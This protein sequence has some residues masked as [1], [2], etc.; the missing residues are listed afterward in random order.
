MAMESLLA[1]G[2][3]PLLLSLLGVAV[4]CGLFGYGFRLWHR[5]RLIEDVP[6]AKIRSMPLGRVEIAGRAREKELLEAPISGVPCV[7]FRYQVEEEVGSGRHRRWRTVARGDSSETPFYV[8]DETGR[9]RVDPAGATLELRADLSR[10]R[11]RPGDP[12]FGRLE[13]HGWARRRWLGL[14]RR[15]RVSEW[16]IAPDRPVYVLGVAQ[17]RG[18]LAAER[19]RAIAASLAEVKHD[20][21]ALARLDR[22]GD[23]RVDA[24]EWEVARRA[25]VAAVDLEAPED[26][27]VI[28]RAPA[29]ESAFVLSD[30]PER[31]LVRSLAWRSA[32]SIFGG[33]TLSLGS[34]AVLLNVLNR[35][36]ILGRT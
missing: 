3:Q 25:A 10:E 2:L 24:D 9:V 5:K 17:E 8:E 23:G 34:L 6:T 14:A 36:G 31:A 27:V 28:A 7:F 22:N 12:I 33:A 19:R 20:P 16:R 26:P 11:V 18:A 29:G 35:F 21:A 32:A 4:G 1:A 15:V 30:R 13:A